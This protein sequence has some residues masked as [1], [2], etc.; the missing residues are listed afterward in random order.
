[1]RGEGQGMEGEAGR[2]HRSA[3]MDEVAI[4][5]RAGGIERRAG[6]GIGG[7]GIG[8]G[9]GAGVGVSVGRGGG[10]GGAGGAGGV[11][12][13]V[14]RRVRGRLWWRRCGGAAQQ[15]GGVG[16]GE[17]SRLVED[18]PRAAWVGLG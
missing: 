12:G 2:G 7:G 1:M 10:V 6:G 9:R 8:R 13:S 18:H 16:E 3:Q 5:R 14:R 17:R 11:V 15:A 4:E